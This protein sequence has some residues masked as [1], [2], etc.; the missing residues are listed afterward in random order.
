MPGVVYSVSFGVGQKAL[1]TDIDA[2]LFARFNVGNRVLSLENLYGI[3]AKSRLERGSSDFWAEPLN[4]TLVL[5]F[6]C[7]ILAYDHSSSIYSV[8]GMHQYY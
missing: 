2:E 1:E 5:V 3:Q 4:N 6:M 7:N 8:K